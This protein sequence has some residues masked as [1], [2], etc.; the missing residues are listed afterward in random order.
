MY[1]VCLLY[2]NRPEHLGFYQKALGDKCPFIIE[3]C[4]MY[5]GASMDFNIL[6][7]GLTPKIFSTLTNIPYIPTTKYYAWWRTSRLS[8]VCVWGGRRQPWSHAPFFKR[9]SHS[10]ELTKWD[11]AASKSQGST[12]VSPRAWITSTHSHTWFLFVLF[13]NMGSE[14]RIQAIVTIRQV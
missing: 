4:L 11:W 8:G 10:L 13:L 7:H 2:S 14:D 5:C 9:V 12:S 3:S 1:K 6:P